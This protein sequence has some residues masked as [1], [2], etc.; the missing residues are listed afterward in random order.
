LVE[1]EPCQDFAFHVKKE[2]FSLAI[3]TDG[4]GDSNYFRSER[5]ARYAADSAYRCIMEYIETIE[6]EYLDINILNKDMWDTLLSVLEQ[7]IVNKW[8]EKVR[9]DCIDNPITT[10]ELLNVSGEYR[11]YYQNGQRLECVYGTTLLALAVTERYWFALQIGDGKCVVVYPDGTS[12][13]P[14]S[15]DEECYLNITT[16][17]CNMN[18]AQQFRHYVS[19]FSHDEKPVAVFIGTDGVDNSYPKKNN[20]K[21][22]AQL[23]KTIAFTF[24]EKGLEFAEKQLQEFLSVMTR[25]GS[26]DDASIAGFIDTAK[27]LKLRERKIRN[28]RA[29][30]AA[31]MEK[32]EAA[33]ESRILAGEEEKKV[34]N[35]ETYADIPI[36]K[37]ATEEKDSEEVVIP[38]EEVLDGK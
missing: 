5:G 17:L 11:E 21:Y 31:K 38:E 25:E 23:Y 29:K 33:I 2:N 9:Q 20:D 15:W 24:A 28:D 30:E 35:Y 1:N 8:I 12:E 10:K 16:S 4:H 18:A 36:I 14:I 27:A 3:V 26:G 19:S 22:L 32:L 37:S 34:R 13:Q 7:R 6:K